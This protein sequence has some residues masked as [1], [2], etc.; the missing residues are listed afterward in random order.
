MHVYM[1]I[2]RSALFLPA[3]RLRKGMIMAVN[4]SNKNVKMKYTNV[5]SKGLEVKKITVVVGEELQK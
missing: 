3:L 5:L 4:K 2:K 1:R